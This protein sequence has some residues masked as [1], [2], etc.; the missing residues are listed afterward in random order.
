[1]RRVCA[2]QA[3]QDALPTAEVLLGNMQGSSTV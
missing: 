1:M 3:T 2:D